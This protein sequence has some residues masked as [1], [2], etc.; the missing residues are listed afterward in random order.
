MRTKMPEHLKV[1]I[2]EDTQTDYELILR[3]LQNGGFTTASSRVQTADELRKSLSKKWDLIISDFSLPQ[4]DAFES[5]KIVQESDIDIPFIVISGHI[6]EQTAVK[7]MK[8]GAHDYLMKDN[9]ARL[10]P[11]VER[12]LREAHERKK[13]RKADAELKKIEWLLSKQSDSEPE[14]IDD[15]AYGDLTELNESGIIKQAIGQDLLKNIAG[16]YLGLLDTATAIYEKNGDYALGIFASGWCRFLDKASRNLCQTHDNKKALECGQWLCHESCWT[17][18]SKIAIETGKP[19]EIECNGAL[20]IYGVP[21]RAG[22][23]IIGAINFGHGNPPDD[24]EKLKEIA[25]KYKVDIQELEKLAREY[26]SRPPYIIEK[27]KRRLV[28]TARLIGEIVER[29]RTQDQLEESRTRL[30]DAQRLAKTGNMTWYIDSGEVTWSEGMCELMGY[31][32]SEAISYNKALEDILH[33]DDR[34]F[35]RNWIEKGTSAGDEILPTL[36]HRL[37]KKDG[38]EIYVHTIGRVLY[39]AGKPFELFATVQDITEKKIAEAEKRKTDKLLKEMSEIAHV[40]GWEHDLVSK[41]ATWTDELYSIIGI[42]DGPP[43]GPDEHLDYYPPEDRKMLEKAYSKAIEEGESF[44]MVLRCI[45][46]KGYPIWARAIGKPEFKNG[47]CIKMRGTFQDITE[48]KKLQDERDKL[49]HDMGERVKELNCIYDITKAIYEHNNLDNIFKKVMTHIPPGWQ[50]P[51][52]TEA[53]ITFDDKEFTTDKFKKTKWK[54][55]G[56]ITVNNENRGS[57]EVYYLE[58]KPEMNGDPFLK[59]E[60]ELIT[61]IARLLG[62][63]IERKIAAESLAESQARYHDLYSSAPAAYFSIGQ[64]GTIENANTAAEEFT[65]LILEEMKKKSILGLYAA[66]SQDKAREIFTQVKIGKSY[67]NEEMV[68][69]RKDGAKVYGLLYI[70]PV[71]DSEGNFA[72]S[73]SIVIDI[74]ER[75]KLEDQL[76]RAS[77]MEAV[78]RLAG[79]IAHDFNNALT[80]IIIV[81][82]LRLQQLKDDDKIKK[83]FREI[84]NASDRCVNL[85]RQLLAFGRQQPFEMEVCDLNKVVIE[86]K[87]MLARIIGEDI[88][89][90]NNLADNLDNI[91]ADI[92]QLE[93]IIVNLAVNARDAMP[94]GGKLILETENVDLKEPMAGKHFT[95]PAGRYVKLSISDT[96]IGMDEETKDRLFE[97]FFTTKERGQGTGLGL[98]TVYGIIK[99]SG[100]YIWVYSEEGKGT[101]F[102]IYLPRETAA[103]EEPKPSRKKEKHEF[104]G[105]ETILL[106]EDDNEVR[107][108]AERILVEFGYKVIVA[109]NG[110]KALDLASETK[111]HIDLLVTDVIMPGLSGNIVAEHLVVDYP[112]LK[113]LYIS[114]YTDDAIMHHG[115]LEKGTNFI[116]K[117]FT[118]LSLTEKIRKVLDDTESTYG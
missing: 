55:A 59:E 29:K 93:Q 47:K 15:L 23:E 8:L 85:T 69:L 87:S 106:V 17:D 100:G 99:Q 43:P 73:R 94:E 16:D 95:M 114:G 56:N 57:V 39:K 4:F 97:P 41:S 46:R 14:N 88:E 45:T 83:D 58:Q 102:K 71:K 24:P 28:S 52:I 48:S 32:K 109:E 33:P 9:L 19:V 36:E 53:R 116:Q 108:V 86:M 37:I 1:L 67:D 54:L 98:S 118:I 60:S 79:G 13:R 96:G 103:V 61:T 66:E 12:E 2:I 76:N 31:D 107:N 34:E 111:E 80:P 18:N 22:D 112:D 74:T 91:K 11:V 63:S 35:V 92:G 104:R 49:L 110:Q 21:I 50:Y 70:S 7:V 75:R 51:E 27:A 113:V 78:G 6:G 72:G 89:L 10:V 30:V 84:L 82:E 77:R 117:P 81:S 42:K 62:E 115:V 5:L 68:Y 101:T 40:G 3:E 44:D 38:A 26:R 20:K 64:D 90:I 25:D 65:G 105:T